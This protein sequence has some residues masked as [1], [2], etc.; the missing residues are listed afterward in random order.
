MQYYRGA[1]AIGG[2]VAEHVLTAILTA[3]FIAKAIANGFAS[4]NTTFLY[5]G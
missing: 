2:Y 4:P 1:N 3:E 5:G